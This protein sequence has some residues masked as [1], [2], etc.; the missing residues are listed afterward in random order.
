MVPPTFFFPEFLLKM[1]VTMNNKGYGIN[2]IDG[3][4]EAARAAHMAKLIDVA[5]QDLNKLETMMVFAEVPPPPP[6][7]PLP[8]APSPC[9]WFT[10]WRPSA[11]LHPAVAASAAS[12]TAPP[13]S[14]QA[15]TGVVVADEPLAFL[16]AQPKGDACRPPVE[17]EP[18]S[19]QAACA[20]EARPWRP[21]PLRHR[22]G[23]PR[24]WRARRAHA[25]VAG[26]RERELGPSAPPH[27]QVLRD[28]RQDGGGLSRPREGLHQ[29]GLRDLRH[30]ALPRQPALAVQAA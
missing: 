12:V 17:E 19:L 5:T 20:P 8:P 25:R 13:P 18:Q 22:P 30:G 9:T 21:R 26:C 16:K 7:R 6:P 28:G 2:V 24:E 1:L 15:D 29:Q 27:A 14:H 3:K 4:T 10:T 11:F 23:P